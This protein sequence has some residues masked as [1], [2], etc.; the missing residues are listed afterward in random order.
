MK[1]LRPFLI[2]AIL[3]GVAGW[4]FFNSRGRAVQTASGA[5]LGRLPGSV[6]PNQ[7]NVL[8][9][10]LDTT[11]W[12]RI[13]AYGDGAAVTPHLDRLAGEGVLFEQAIAPAPLTLPA[14]STLFTG[15]LPP[16]HGVRDNGGY[17]LDARHATMASALKASGRQTGAFVGAFV[18]DGKFGLDSGFDTYHD[19]F[20]LSRQRSVSL[21]S[22][23][24]RA[25]EVVDNAMPWLEE[26]ASRPFFAWLHFYD[27]HSPYDPPEPFLS[28]FRDRPYAGEIAYV[29][30]Q[31]GRLLQW[32]DTKGLT[33]RTVV[34][35]I[36]D[37]GESLNEHGEA[38]HGLFIYEATTR[39]PFL[40]RAPYSNARGRR[41]PGVVRTEDVLP[42]VLEL[43]GRRAPEGIQ[44]RSLAPML[45]GTSSDLNLDAYS[46][47]LY[48]RNHYG[49]SELRSL[50]SGRFKFIA[51][52][53]PELYDLERDPRERQ[54]LYAERRSL[55]DRMAS[56]LQRLSAEEQ[57]AASGPS[58]V[59]P[60]TRERLAALGYI[61]SFS[62]VARKPGEALPDPKDKIDIFNLM[63]SAHESKGED[64]TDAAIVRLKKVLSQDPNILDAWVMLGNEY[65][66]KRDYQSALKQYQRALHINPDYDLATINLA[67]AY[68]ALGQYEA[69]LL[70][71]Q[72]YLERDPKNALVR[73][74]MG[75]LYVDLSQLDQAESA[76]RQALSD[77]TRVAAARNALGV[78]AF[79]RGD[80]PRAEQEIGAALAQRPDVALAHFNLALIAEERGDLQKAEAEY[81][82]EI[83]MQ[84]GAF[85]AAFNL[86]N[87]R[88]RMSD[89]AGQEAAYR[90]SIELNPRFA[91][92]YF[93]LAKLYLDQGRQLDEAIALAQRGLELGPNSPYAPLGHYVL[94][95]IYS[96][97][98]MLAQSRREADRGR[99]KERLRPE[100]GAGGKRG[101]S[102][103]PERAR[104]GVGPREH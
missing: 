41:V 97:R 86:A 14:H 12:D 8:L 11:R 20:D 91:E 85:K 38:T 55:A 100:R 2:V 63:T 74:Q 77:D 98:G 71:Y 70:G 39:V 48:A 1:R 80:L 79:K 50:R 82:K 30:S 10:T 21:G 88:A 52:T 81:Q 25:A 67:H 23:S 76:F 13:G 103:A 84:A 5:D 29:D 26:H 31:V 61:G 45:A 18:L 57:G 9:V 102:R 62:H 44:G 68:R 46:E 90:K 56:E 28:R 94:A 3:L 92:G 101:A 24:R 58:T 17:V 37:H 96:R 65:S 34:V 64:E 6:R 78:V 40:I 66:R 22:I 35:V 60:E 36:G 89:A 73:Y 32:L 95:D 69:A 33:D 104:A 83:D 49:W 15:L 27:A 4:W 54:N 99:A 42:T 75:E 93:Y 19:K 51:T 16:R 53:R 72:R 7:L 47:S 43:V 59:D 87:L